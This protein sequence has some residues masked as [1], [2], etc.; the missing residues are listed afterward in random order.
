MKKTNITLILLLFLHGILNAQNKGIPVAEMNLTG[1][2]IVSCPVEIVDKATMKH[3]EL[4]TVQISQENPGKAQIHDFEMDFQADKIIMKHGDKT[5]TVSYTRNPDNHS[6]SFAF[7]NSKFH[8]RSFI[9]NNDRI[10]L[11]HDG[12]ILYLTKAE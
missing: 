8:F 3:C 1:K 7:G 9:N 4:C 2:W 10:L 11:N 5:S 12:T 6:I